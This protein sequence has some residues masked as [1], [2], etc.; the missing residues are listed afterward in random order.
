MRRKGAE[1]HETQWNG[2]SWRGD[3]RCMVR[4]FVLRYEISYRCLRFVSHTSIRR[5]SV[6]VRR[7]VCA[8]FVLAQTSPPSPPLQKVRPS[9]FRNV[10]TEEMDLRATKTGKREKESVLSYRESLYPLTSSL[11]K[12]LIIERG[13]LFHAPSYEILPRVSLPTLFLV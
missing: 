7:L 5:M 11:V 2:D 8:P 3:S 4:D 13:L 1:T 9:L 10:R 12:T 6:F